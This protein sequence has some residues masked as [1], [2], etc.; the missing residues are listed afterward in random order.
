MITGEIVSNTFT[1]A[2]LVLTFPLISTTD[3]IT[4]STPTSEQLKVYLSKNIVSTPQLSNDELSMSEV[5]I[6]TLPA[7]SKY[8]VILFTF[9]V[10][11]MPSL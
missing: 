1:V 9:T 10:G 5:F 8:A 11:N 4:V 7:L 6:V 2:F 3:N